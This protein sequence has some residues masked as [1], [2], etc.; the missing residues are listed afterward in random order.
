MAVMP[1]R[2]PAVYP[3]HLFLQREKGALEMPL[4]TDCMLY[5]HGSSLLIPTSEMKHSF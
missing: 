3:E 4:A 5:T 2:S 1:V